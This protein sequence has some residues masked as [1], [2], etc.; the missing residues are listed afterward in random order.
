[1]HTHSGES[2]NGRPLRI[3]QQVHPE[4]LRGRSKAMQR[5]TMADEA[6]QRVTA[7]LINLPVQRLLCYLGPSGNLQLPNDTSK[8][9]PDYQ[10]YL[11]AQRVFVQCM[12]IRWVA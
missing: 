10:T 9:Q 8:C 4:R 12:H 3:T 2:R 7:L 11:V 6:D 1:M 5:S